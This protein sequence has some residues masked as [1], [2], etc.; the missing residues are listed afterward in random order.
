MNKKLRFLTVFCAIGLLPMLIA[1][2]ILCVFSVNKITDS[3]KKAIYTELNVAAEG[4]NQYYSHDLVAG[5][6]IPYDHE[7]VDSQKDKDIELTLFIGDERYVTSI[8][9]AT[10]NKR[11]EGTKADANIYKEVCNNKDYKADGVVIGGRDYYVYYLPIA[12]ENGKVIGM[13]FAGKSEQS[14][15]D[16]IIN[17]VQGMVVITCILIVCLSLVIIAIALK[18]KKPI[19]E[20]AE[21]TKQFAAGNLTG[22][23]KTESVIREVHDLVQAA[24]YLKES[25]SGVIVGVNNNATELNSNMGVVA[26][27]VENCNSTSDGILV[28]VDAITQ[29][30]A[31]M[32][33]SVEICSGSIQTIGE[34]ISEIAGLADTVNSN[35]ADV[36][37]VSRKAIEQLEKLVNANINTVDVSNKVVIGINEANEAA[38]KIRLAAEVITGIASET[39]LL[40]L[41]A[42]IEAARAGESG[43]GFAVVAS[44][45]QSLAN[46]SDT[47]AQ[48]I[49]DI[50]THIISISNQN[51]SL[52]NNIK[53]VIN[54]EGAVL[55]SVNASY[56][57]VSSK[58]DEIADK[59]NEIS[60]MAM[61]L[62]EEKGIV[63][64]EISN[65]SAISEEN[66][67][68]CEET[69]TSMESLKTKVEEIYEK[70]IDTKTVSGQLTDAVAYFNL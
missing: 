45:I 28:A 18:I 20:V 54:E 40:A 35:S 60:K 46:Q 69:N 34:N 27:K 62:D 43:A 26:E 23:Q 15:S 36:K 9:D 33:N 17:A 39:D 38:K 66:A 16:E 25:L 3:L 8:V 55:K 29:G 44:N 41:N 5:N 65:L 52:A 63:I 4:L 31:D 13:A 56:G 22:E 70:A 67:V 51:V 11:N 7:F 32:A 61:E 30:A 42:S 59:I 64:D 14:V 68:S 12:D 1:S 2:I 48:E 50:I 57:I 47:A 24:E 53:N 37:I 21:R 49:Q 10:T 19:V 58:I 6:D